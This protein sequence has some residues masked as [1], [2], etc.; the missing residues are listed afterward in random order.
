[1]ARDAHSGGAPK[2]A[3]IKPTKKKMSLSR[4]TVRHLGD[5]DLAV[6]AGGIRSEDRLTCGQAACNPTRGE[7]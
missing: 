2:E 4:E 1:M 7:E 6:A 5:I 3:S